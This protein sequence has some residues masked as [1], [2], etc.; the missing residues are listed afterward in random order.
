M[1]F[2]SPAQRKFVMG[3]KLINDK[4]NLPFKQEPKYDNV[5]FTKKGLRDI[6]YYKN[7]IVISE[8]IDK[9]KIINK[10]YAMFAIKPSYKF[11]RIAQRFKR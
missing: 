5:Y 9:S 1:V 10:G 7:L 11:S 2:K 6:P 8:K 3:Y 4:P